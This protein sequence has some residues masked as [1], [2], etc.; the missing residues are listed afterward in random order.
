MKH[1]PDFNTE[2]RRSFNEGEDKGNDILMEIL[3]EENKT[4]KS[5]N[6]YKT[7]L[8]KS[9]INYPNNELE[10]YNIR[11]QLNVICKFEP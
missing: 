7:S 4:Y 9:L 1:Y 8:N 10:Y 11:G 2:E 3:L 5:V 6:A